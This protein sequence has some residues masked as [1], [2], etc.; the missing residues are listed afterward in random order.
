MVLF[1]LRPEEHWA[2]G[3]QRGLTAWAGPTGCLG[4]DCL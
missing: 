2:I 3:D 4:V 1:A